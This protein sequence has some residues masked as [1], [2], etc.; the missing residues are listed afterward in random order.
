MKI[1]M[2]RKRWL[3][4]IMSF[5]GKSIDDKERKFIKIHDYDTWDVSYTLSP[6]IL[7]LLKKYQKLNRGIA[8]IDEE[9][10]PED[11]RV[12]FTKEERDSLEFWP[13]ESYFDWVLNEMIWTFKQFTINWEEQFHHGEID[14]KFEEDEHGRFILK[15]GPNDTFWLD[16]EGRRAH[17]ERMKNGLR[18]FGKYYENLWW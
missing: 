7:E 6:I 9:D 11:I 8:W 16:E 3:Q 18:L 5:F 14:F 12:N 1:I 13:P 15:K 2:K 10:V 4:K 17:Y